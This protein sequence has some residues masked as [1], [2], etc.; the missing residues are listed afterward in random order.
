MG[1]PDAGPDLAIALGRNDGPFGHLYQAS[2]QCGGLFVVEHAI[3]VGNEFVAPD[4]GNEIPYEQHILHAASHLLEHGIAGGVAELVIDLLEAVQSTAR[5][6]A[7]GWPVL[8]SRR[9]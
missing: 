5:H 1:N 6:R 2:R 7:F 8:V 3:D 9:A 4:S